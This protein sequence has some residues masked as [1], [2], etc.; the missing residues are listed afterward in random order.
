[1]AAYLSAIRAAF[2]QQWRE[3]FT[4][5]GTLAP[6][7]SALSLAIG[8][9]WVVGRSD[10]PV[11]LSY[12]FVGAPLTPSIDGESYAGTSYACSKRNSGRNVTVLPTQK[13]N[14][15]RCSVYLV[16]FPVRWPLMSSTYS[17]RMLNELW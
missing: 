2:K 11:A 5:G 7:L 15:T 9:G 3:Q 6:L 12:V 17:L 4:L 10:N 13:L 14:P 8:V 1:M 16:L